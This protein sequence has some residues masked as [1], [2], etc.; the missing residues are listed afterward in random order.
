M[1]ELYRILGLT[2][3]VMAHLCNRLAYS[4]YNLILTWCLAF[5]WTKGCYVAGDTM[6][7][8]QSVALVDVKGTT[9][10]TQLGRDSSLRQPFVSTSPIKNSVPNI[11]TL[12][13]VLLQ[14]YLK[15]HCRIKH[16]THPICPFHRSSSDTC[17]INMFIFPK[18]FSA[19]VINEYWQK[20]LQ[21]NTKGEDRCLLNCLIWAR[22]K[23][24]HWFCTVFFTEGWMDWAPLVCV[25]WWLRLH[26]GKQEPHPRV[27]GE[28]PS[29]RGRRLPGATWRGGAMRSNLW[30]SRLSH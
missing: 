17:S 3:L 23:T 7:R 2:L 26:P 9:C 5:Y 28:A 25:C 27:R 18:R 10:T 19:E 12:T 14:F 11:G 8:V 20:K 30:I 13:K 4:V 24:H 1:Q 15:F 29:V 6:V 16:W 21:T 22:K